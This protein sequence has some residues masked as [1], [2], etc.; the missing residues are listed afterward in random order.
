MLQGTKIFLV[1][2]PDAS[3]QKFGNTFYCLILAK[4]RHHEL[5]SNK[6]STGLGLRAHRHSMSS[7]QIILLK[8]DGL[9]LMSLQKL[10]CNHQIEKGFLLKSVKSLLWSSGNFK[11]FFCGLGQINFAFK[12]WISFWVS[13][14]W[15]IMAC[16]KNR[17]LLGPSFQS[18]KP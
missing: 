14:T 15:L 9:L 2:L 6:I 13:T 10:I 18:F 12:R 8:V 3:K 16:G 17:E 7:F 11:S 4:K 5:F 1:K